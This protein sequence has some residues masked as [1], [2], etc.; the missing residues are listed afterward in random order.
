[1][2]DDFLSFPAVPELRQTAGADQAGCGELPC[3]GLTSLLVVLGSPDEERCLVTYY[4]P[5]VNVT[6]IFLVCSAMLGGKIMPGPNLVTLH[7][8]NQSVCFAGCFRISYFLS[9]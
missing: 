8:C 3:V 6:S 7:Q 2:T 5:Q 4:L 1:M 9:E